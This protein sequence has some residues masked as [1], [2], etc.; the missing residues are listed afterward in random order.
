[1]FIVVSRLLWHG[2]LFGSANVF[3]THPRYGSNGIDLINELEERNMEEKDIGFEPGDT[4]NRDGCEGTMQDE[5]EGGCSC[6]VNPPCSHC[7]TTET[8]CDTCEEEFYYQA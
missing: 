6:H 4:C 1:M 8:I 5:R 7:C 3:I 2:R